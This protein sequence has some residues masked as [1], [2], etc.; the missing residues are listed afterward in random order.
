MP[1][2]KT[3]LPRSRYPFPA[4]QHPLRLCPVSI[5]R[6]LWCLACPIGLITASSV[7]L[8][9]SLQADCKPHEFEDLRDGLVFPQT[10]YPESPGVQSKQQDPGLEE[11]ALDAGAPDQYL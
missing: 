8:E 2:A 4:L 6:V 3:P 9:G 5:S 1:S 11:G 7:T 10:L